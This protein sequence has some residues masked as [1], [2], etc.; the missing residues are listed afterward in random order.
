MNAASGA[1]ALG[2]LTQDFALVI[3]SDAA[4]DLDALTLG[5]PAVT[6]TPEDP[7]AEPLAS[8]SSASGV[9]AWTV[10]TGEKVSASSP[11]PA[12]NTVP[13]PDG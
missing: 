8:S 6:S 7:A 1:G 3:S 12:T 9:C 13:L 2:T 4:T 11:W 10:L 5:A